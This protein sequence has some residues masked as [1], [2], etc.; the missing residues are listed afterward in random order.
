VDVGA[1][2]MSAMKEAISVADRVVVPV[3]PSQPD[4]WATQRFLHIV[5]E[6]TQNGHKP[7]LYVFVN[8]ADT[9]CAVRE[10][11]ETEEV[12]AQLPGMTLIPHRLYQRTIYRRSLSEGLGIFELSRRSKAVQEFDALAQALFPQVGGAKRSK[13]CWLIFTGRSYFPQ[14]SS[15]RLITS[16]SASPSGRKRQQQVSHRKRKSPQPIL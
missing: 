14:I 13:A 4:V 9:H 3:P 12:L 5:D 7:E 16:R 6:A 11:D 1:A 10:S 15:A 8:R 2:N